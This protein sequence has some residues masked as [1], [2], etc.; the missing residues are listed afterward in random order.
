MKYYI[1]I[2]S[3]LFCLGLFLLSSASTFAQTGIITG[4]IANDLSDEVLVGST[5]FISEL[6]I[7]TLSDETGAF[8]FKNLNPGTYN[9]TI[10][11]LGHCP[12]RRWRQGGADLPTRF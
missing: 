11:M 4:R 7:G 1:N 6:N 8:R 12:T 5:I 10:S 2:I 3:S 9:L